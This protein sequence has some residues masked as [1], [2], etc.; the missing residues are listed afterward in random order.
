M[1]EIITASTLINEDLAPVP[2]SKRYWRPAA[3]STDETS[4]PL[5]SVSMKCAPSFT[6]P[7]FPNTAV[8]ATLFTTT[9]E[10]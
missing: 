5:E 2:Q 10:E 7:S 8:G 3:T 1:T 9:V 4:V 6:G